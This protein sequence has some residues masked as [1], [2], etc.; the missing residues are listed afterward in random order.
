MQSTK[1]PTRKTLDD[2][3]LL[4]QEIFPGIGIA[5]RQPGLTVA[6]PLQ[7]RKNVEEF[8]WQMLLALS[9]GRYGQCK[10]SNRSPNS[11]VFSFH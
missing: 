9:A 5:E 10:K 4:S 2:A 1:T 6:K 8:C 3:I 11:E 7:N